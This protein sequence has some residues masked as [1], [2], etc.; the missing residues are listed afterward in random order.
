[1]VMESKQLSRITIIV[2]LITVIFFPFE[3]LVLSH[4]NIELSAVRWALALLSESLIFFQ[5]FIYQRKGYKG[6]RFVLFCL[7]IYTLFL[8]ASTLV[9]IMGDALRLKIFISN[10][11]LVGLL[12]LLLC[13]RFTI[14]DVKLVVKTC[15]VLMP[16]IIVVLIVCPFILTEKKGVSMEY[17]SY[18]YGSVLGLLLLLSP[19]QSRSKKVVLLNIVLVFMLVTVMIA[20][21][22]AATLFLAFFFLGEGYMNRT[23]R[24]GMLNSNAKK[25]G[26]IVMFF[27]IIFVFVLVVYSQF[28]EF[29]FDRFKTGFDS[30]EGVVDDFIYDFNRTNDWIIGRGFVGSVRADFVATNSQGNRYGIE[31]AWLTTILH[32][33]VVLLLIRLSIMVEAIIIS[34]KANNR[35]CKAL[36]LFVAYEIIDGI[37]FGVEFINFKTFLTYFAISCC[38]STELLSL[39]DEEILEQIYGNA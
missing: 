34:F 38:H 13:V 6:S 15:G 22:R 5:I 12:P 4:Y 9:G 27:I 26:R 19:Y 8:I 30:R 14:N 25:N 36:A 21:R 39:N 23:S 28:F 35:F 20:G 33:G 10:S 17:Y 2:L 37:G 7:E 1:M 31:S 24:K 16:F 3:N 18:A 29:I 32:G 11:L